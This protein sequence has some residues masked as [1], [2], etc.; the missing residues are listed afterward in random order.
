MLVTGTHAWRGVALALTRAANEGKANCT[1]REGLVKAM[2]QRA[3][4]LLTIERVI[5]LCLICGRIMLLSVSRKP[6]RT[7]A[8]SEMSSFVPPISPT[9]STNSI[10]SSVVEP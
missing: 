7:R 3:Q 1:G 8:I 5:K 2:E 6:P 9:R 4:V 10:S